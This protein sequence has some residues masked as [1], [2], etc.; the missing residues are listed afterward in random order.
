MN[1][2]IMYAGVATVS[3]IG[4][5]IIGR[6]QE[7]KII[8]CELADLNKNYLQIDGKRITVHHELEFLS[9][10]RQYISQGGIP[11]FDYRYNGFKKT[12]PWLDKVLKTE[13]DTN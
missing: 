12:D 11:V 8:A 1:R 5:N 13:N 3:F 7:N 4:G 9:S 10:Q 6:N 2:L